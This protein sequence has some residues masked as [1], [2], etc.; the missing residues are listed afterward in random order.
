MP[1]E[2]EIDLL[3]VHQFPQI[4]QGWI[5]IGVGGSGPARM[6]AGDDDALRS[7]LRVGQLRLEPVPHR[8]A[9]VSATVTTAGPLAVRVDDNHTPLAVDVECVVALRGHLAARPPPSEA[10]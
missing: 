4:V 8:L 3:V 6:V 7:C 1:G 10:G 2:E 9:L 5:R